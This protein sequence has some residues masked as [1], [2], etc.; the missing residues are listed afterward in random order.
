M[1]EPGGCN[2]RHRILL[3]AL[4]AIGAAALFT[5]NAT[6]GGCGSCGYYAPP[7]TV[8]ARYT[9]QPKLIVRRA[10]VVQQPYYLS[11]Y[12]PCGNGYAVNQGQYHTEASLIAQPRCFHR[13]ARAWYPRHYHTAYI[14]AE[15]PCYA[16]RLHRGYY[17]WR[18][19]AWHRANRHGRYYHRTHYR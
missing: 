13:Y 4:L 3:S 2:M 6:A 12:V 8:I 7:V 18:G 17:H 19:I 10:F 11:E 16:A 9:V 5:G 1:V 14:P 15:R